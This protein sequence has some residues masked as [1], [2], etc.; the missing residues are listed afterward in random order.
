MVRI[1]IR[2]HWL[3]GSKNSLWSLQTPIQKHTVQLHEVGGAESDKSGW[4]SWGQAVVSR[5]YHFRLPF[6]KW[7]CPSHIHKTKFS[8]PTD[9]MVI[10]VFQAAMWKQ[11]LT[12]GPHQPYP[13]TPWECLVTTAEVVPGRVQASKQHRQSHNNPQACALTLTYLLV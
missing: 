12:H 11:P 4:G 1:T 2:A 6:Y 13:N 3:G 5:G 7:C 9:R 10:H 8:F